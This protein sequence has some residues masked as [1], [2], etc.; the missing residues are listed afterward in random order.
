MARAVLNDVV[1]AESDKYE[2]V[3]GNI[4]FPQDSVKWDYSKPGDRQCTCAWKGK[5]KYYDIVVGDKIEK[6]A[7]SRKGGSGNDTEAYY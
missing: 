6:N 4:Y 2:V 5:S 7:A 3:E 1:L